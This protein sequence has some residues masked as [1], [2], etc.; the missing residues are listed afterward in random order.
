V[1]IS[2]GGKIIGTSLRGEA[3]GAAVEKALAKK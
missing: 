1:L 2:T 3:L